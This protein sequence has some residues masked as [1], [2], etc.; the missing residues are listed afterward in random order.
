MS[1][2][3]DILEFFGKLQENP[4]FFLIIKCFSL[5]SVSYHIFFQ[6]KKIILFARSNKVFSFEV[7]YIS[8]DSWKGLLKDYIILHF[9]I[10]SFSSLIV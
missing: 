8:Y 7:V 5:F 3:A 6:V 1:L 2:I 10:L 9:K 4:T